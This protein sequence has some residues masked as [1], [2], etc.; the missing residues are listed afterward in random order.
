MLSACIPPIASSEEVCFSLDEVRLNIVPNLEL[1]PLLKEN[2]QIL[3]EQNA[4]LVEQN[5]L[6]KESLQLWQD[7][8]ASAENI[9]LVE[10]KAREAEKKNLEDQLKEAKKTPWGKLG[11]SFGA[12]SLL[13][14]VGMVLLLL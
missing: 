6:L 8:F 1:V 2:N 3:R 11:L 14:I 10:K 13:T 12:G 5:D 9:A 4:K 7:K